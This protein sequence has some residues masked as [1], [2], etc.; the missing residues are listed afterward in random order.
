MQQLGQNQ[1]RQNCQ[2]HLWQWGW[3]LWLQFHSLN[4]ISAFWHQQ[5]QGTILFPKAVKK[6]KSSAYARD[7]KRREQIPCVICCKSPAELKYKK[8]NWTQT[9]GWVRIWLGN[10]WISTLLKWK[11]YKSWMFSYAEI[12]SKLYYYLKLFSCLCAGQHHA[13]L[14]QLELK[15]ECKTKWNLLDNGTRLPLFLCL[16]AEFP[17]PFPDVSYPLAGTVNAA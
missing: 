7:V 10:F 14:G 12:F 4:A 3:D 9:E 15:S 17:C 8:D 16:P 13:E 1:R 6:K 5:Q 2:S 11:H